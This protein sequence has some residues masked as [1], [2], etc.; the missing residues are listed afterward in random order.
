MRN[1]LPVCP[2]SSSVTQAR[3]SPALRRALCGLAAG[4]YYFAHYG[5]APYCDKPYCIASASSHR[6]R[7]S[8]SAATSGCGMGSPSMDLTTTAMRTEDTS[9]TASAVNRSLGTRTVGVTFQPQLAA[10]SN[11]A[12]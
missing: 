8:F 1:S 4:L 5:L 7:N 12:A 3:F 9:H 2:R 6:S 11:S 10:V